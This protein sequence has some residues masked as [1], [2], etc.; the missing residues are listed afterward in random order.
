MPNTIDGMADVLIAFLDALGL[1]QVDVL[2]WSLGGFVNQ[3][4]ALKALERV[5]RLVIAGSG[6]GGISEGSEHHPKVREVMAHPQNDEEDFLF[7]FFSPTQTSRAAG[8]AYLFR[9]KGVS[10]RVPAVTGAAFVGQLEAI[11]Q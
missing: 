11:G 1:K 5:R 6:P 9:L 4:A 10:D 8:S 3:H 2:G 7:L